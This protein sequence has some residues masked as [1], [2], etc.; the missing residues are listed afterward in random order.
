MT[1]GATTLTRSGFSSTARIGTTV[2]SMPLT[3]AMPATPGADNCAETAEMKVTDP[4]LVERRQGRL[5]A[6]QLRPDFL[7][8]AAGDVGRGRGVSNGPSPLPPLAAR[9][10]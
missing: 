2:S 1:P 7:V 8:D 9:T 4:D 5:Q 3:A 10:R 6:G